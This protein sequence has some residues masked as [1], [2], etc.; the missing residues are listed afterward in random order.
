MLWAQSAGI[1]S[2][3]EWEILS[4]NRARQAKRS[5]VDLRTRGGEVKQH[6][7]EEACRPRRHAGKYGWG[8]GD[9]ELLRKS[10]RRA[11]NEV[12]SSTEF[13]AHMSARAGEC[14]Q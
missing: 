14:N 12:N 1:T 6:Y 2:P 3:T 7:A 8:E 9:W 11:N 10:V 5:H 4:F 13:G